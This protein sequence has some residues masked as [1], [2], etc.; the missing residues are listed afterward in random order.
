MGAR[1][2]RG[3]GPLKFNAQPA[4]WR[5]SQ[6]QTTSAGLDAVKGDRQTQPMPRVLP[7]QGF[8]QPLARRKPGPTP[9]P[10]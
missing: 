2:L 7:G 9:T 4:R 1:G 3:A 10:E 5:G 6:G 8:S